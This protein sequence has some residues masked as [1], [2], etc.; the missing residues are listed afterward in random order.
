MFNL[1]FDRYI[2]M[3]Q[4]KSHHTARLCPCPGTM[5]LFCIGLGPHSAIVVSC[6]DMGTLV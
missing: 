1:M 6:E 4:I 5:T 2:L 3:F